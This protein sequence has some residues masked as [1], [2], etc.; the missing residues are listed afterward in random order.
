MILGTHT[1]A[2]YC[3]KLPRLSEEITLQ[4]QSASHNE[5][6][7]KQNYT[8]L[9]RTHKPLLLVFA[10]CLL[11][12][13]VGSASLAQADTSY[14]VQPG[15]TLSGIAARYGTTID[16]IVT[17]NH[18]SSRTIYSGQT[19]DIP[20]GGAQAAP[21]SGTYTVQPGDTLSGIAARFGTT[22]QALM[23][24]NGLASTAIYAGQVL[25]IG[26]PGSV[27]STATKAPPL[28]ATPTGAPPASTAAAQPA[29]T[30]APSPPT[31]QP[32][33][34]ATRPSTYTVQSGDSLTALAARFGLSLQAL[35]AANGLST[36]SYL[37]V[38][39]TLN[40][41]AIGA[42][43]ATSTAAPTKP[44]Q[45]APT[46]QS[47]QALPT[48]SGTPNA[49]TTTP[50]PVTAPGNTAPGQPVKYTVQPGDSLSSIATKFHTTLAAIATLNN[51]QDINYVY[52]GEVL[53]IIAGNDQ[54]SDMPV[55]TPVPE[56][57]PPMGQ[58]GPKWVDV[59]LNT[60]TMVAYEGNTPVYTSKVSSGVPGHPTVVGIYRVYL[61][62]T[63]TRMKGGTPGIDYYDIPNVPWT[64]YFYADYALHGAYWH[65]NF[66]HPMS[67]GCVNLPVDV[68][69][70]MYNWAPIGTLV[71][72]HP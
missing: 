5:G 9:L 14:R 56:P 16:A 28:P 12:S 23:Q 68:S 47:T 58:F 20:T 17:A 26:G 13:L 18:L 42:P 66:G 51:M 35:A 1:D 50:Q 22:T 61:K 30:Q 49:A 11:V 72:T 60:Q 46:A 2:V 48:S 41:P 38:G 43:V 27:P 31:Q 37:Y 3:G 71:V 7:G 54:S 36:S 53:T 34:P 63:S 40:I 70:W 62:Y 6:R 25:R 64:M 24:A 8:G 39:Q 21:A 59:S 15:D 52:T 29:N 10:L 67:H 4:D 33:Q 32:S 19:L 44:T 57:P 45:P 69:Q 65:H 55:A